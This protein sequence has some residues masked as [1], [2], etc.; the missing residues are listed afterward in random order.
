MS[1]MRAL[2]DTYDNLELQEKI[3]QLLDEEPDTDGG[4]TRLTT[5]DLVLRIFAPSCP[6]SPA[7]GRQNKEII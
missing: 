4:V 1:W 2:Y 6:N 3:R 5:G 7:A